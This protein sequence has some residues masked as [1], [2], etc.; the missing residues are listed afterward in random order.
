MHFSFHPQMFTTRQEMYRKC[1]NEIFS[2]LYGHL[3]LSIFCALYIFPLI[4]LNLV[5]VNLEKKKVFEVSRKNPF[6]ILII[7]HCCIE[8]L[9]WEFQAYFYTSSKVRIIA[10]AEQVIMDVWSW[11]Q[12]DL[13]LP[14]CARREACIHFSF[15]T[16]WQNSNTIKQSDF[17]P[18]ILKM[19]ATNEKTQEKYVKMT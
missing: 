9:I 10:L 19:Y 11:F 18:K 3:N 6:E 17:N 2:L 15:I 8:L 1:I 7:V 16:L 13:S 5:F 4:N 14:S 12:S